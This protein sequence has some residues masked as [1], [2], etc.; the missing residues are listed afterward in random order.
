M[1]PLKKTIGGGRCGVVL[2]QIKYDINKQ[3]TATSCRNSSLLE[4]SR[5]IT[6]FSRTCAEKID[7]LGDAGAVIPSYVR[8]ER[9][10]VGTFDMSPTALEISE[11]NLTQS[12]SCVE[13]QCAIGRIIRLYYYS[14]INSDYVALC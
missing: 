13:R 6:Q 14:A 10:R 1:F 8:I 4:R 5:T 9:F 7:K 11:S 12:V 3:H 2:P